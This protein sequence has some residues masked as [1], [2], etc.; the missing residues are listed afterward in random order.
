MQDS[1]I[2]PGKTLDVIHLMNDFVALYKGA[3]RITY[4]DSIRRFIGF[5][6]IGRIPTEA[7]VIAFRD[8]MI[9]TG[10][11]PATVNVRLSAVK[12][13]YRHIRKKVRMAFV[14]G[15]ITADRASVLNMM[16]DGILEAKGCKRCDSIMRL[17][18]TPGEI[19]T[20]F[21]TIGTAK[22][23]DLRDRAIIGLMVGCGLRR[24]E[25]LRAVVG[26]V[27]V[28]GDKMFIQIQQKGYDAE[29]GWAVVFG[30]VRAMLE[31]WME[32]S[33][34][35]HPWSPLFPNL[36]DGKEL[37]GRFVSGMITKR[38]DWAGMKGLTGHSLRHTFATIALDGD[39]VDL[40][41]VQQALGHRQVTTTE[42][43]LHTNHRQ[44]GKPEMAVERTIFKA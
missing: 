18:A 24:V 38:F 12:E 31:T 26:H 35:K 41:D 5:C 14:A 21:S 44:E 3:T 30:E 13:F 19:R 28:S 33:P 10:L 9:E 37:T 29:N 27:R 15:D 11:A 2:I 8:S 43:Y 7:D 40:R 16:I 4:T 1:S 36:Q 39:G 25:I 32:T 17:P 20:L 22:A 34:Y 6:G 42:R 23:S